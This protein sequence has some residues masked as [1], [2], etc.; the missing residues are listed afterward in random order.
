[1]KNSTLSS[2]E[3]YAQLSELK[4]DNLAN[5]HGHVWPLDQI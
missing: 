3:L 1:M 5:E 2:Y 4:P